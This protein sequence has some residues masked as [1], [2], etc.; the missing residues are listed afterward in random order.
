MQGERAA[1]VSGTGGLAWWEGM[2]ASPPSVLLIPLSRPASRRAADWRASGLTCLSG[3]VLALEQLSEARAGA[4]RRFSSKGEAGA[5]RGRLE[6]LA[7]LVR[8]ERGSVRRMR[9]YLE[10]VNAQ[11][12]TAWREEDVWD[13][14]CRLRA[15]EID[16][17]VEVETEDESE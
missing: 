5:L 12:P 6:T 4:V 7:A 2:I 11:A 8:Q 13:K 15:N 17:V 9:V 14:A 16:E 10:C 1:A 3:T